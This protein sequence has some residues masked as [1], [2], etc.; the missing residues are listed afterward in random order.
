MSNVNDNKNI[1]EVKEKKPNKLKEWW[2]NN[3]GK[4][5]G[6]AATVAGTAGLIYLGKKGLVRAG[7]T[8]DANM[9]LKYGKAAGMDLFSE[10]GSVGERL[11]RA[12]DKIREDR[13]LDEVD[14]TIKEKITELS[15]LCKEKGYEV[16]I[17]AMLGTDDPICEMET[18]ID[19][20]SV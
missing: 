6:T 10:P 15:D 11:V 3:W 7:E 12:A 4:V 20:I 18:Y 13:N 17:G 19:N 5:V 9:L 14:E 1:A 2:R 8:H 16:S